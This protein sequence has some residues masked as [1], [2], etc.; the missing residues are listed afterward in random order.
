MEEGQGRQGRAGQG[1][2]ELGQ[3]RP[4]RAG[5]RRGSKFHDTHIH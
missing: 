5:S 1:R 2:A 4:S 3:T